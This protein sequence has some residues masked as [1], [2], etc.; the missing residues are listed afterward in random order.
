MNYFVLLI[1]LFLPNVIYAEE[2]IKSPPDLAIGS[3][4]ASLFLVIACIFIFAFLMKKSN[5]LHNGRGKALI[6]VIATQPL[7]NKGRVQIIEVNETRY[8]LGVTE[9]NI[10][11]LG[12]L[13][14]PENE[15]DGT[16][17]SPASTRFATLLS[18][19]S[20]KRNE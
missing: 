8:L 6:K 1:S 20:I 7:T 12:T 15:D 16:Q 9:Q 19:I 3:M 4:I 13:P 18:K 10:N 2:A 14:I 11:L 17:S 5:L